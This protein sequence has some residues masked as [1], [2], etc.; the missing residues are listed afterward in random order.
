VRFAV[1]AAAIA[2]ALAASLA[3]GRRAA[4]VAA[5]VGAGGVLLHGALAGVAEPVASLLPGLELVAVPAT[6]AVLLAVV[7]RRRGGAVRVVAAGFAAV[8]VLV[9]LFAAWAYREAAR[10]ARWLDPRLPFQ[11]HAEA[12]LAI[13]RA[14]P[15]AATLAWAGSGHHEFLALFAGRRLER[16][17]IGV[18]RH[19]D[20]R[21]G[22][23]RAA[24]E[25]GI[26]RVDQGFWSDEIRRRGVD[27]LVASRWG[28]A[29]GRWPIEERWAESAGWPRLVDLPDF[30][31]YEI[32]PASPAQGSRG[33]PQPDSQPRAP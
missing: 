18:A 4:R 5:L 30:R 1:P 2:G 22:F 12:A 23:R 7:A 10:E 13:E 32:R 20:E 11:P 25:H 9:A 3:T 28:A 16:R 8:A 29:L 24:D 14:R 26:V 27:L 17:V 33:G 21:E 6:A 31:V 15:G 19:P